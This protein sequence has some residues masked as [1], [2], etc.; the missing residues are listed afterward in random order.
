[1][2]NEQEMH[3]LEIKH[4]HHDSDSRCTIVDLFEDQ[5]DL[6]LAVGISK[7]QLNLRETLAALRTANEL[8][9]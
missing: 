8:L 5:D 9:I 2:S 6:T 1:M 3:Q 4:I 7:P